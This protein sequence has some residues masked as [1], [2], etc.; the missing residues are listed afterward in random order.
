MAALDA[1][2]AGVTA[3]TVHAAYA[4]VIQGAGYD[5]PFRCGRATG[6]SSLEHPKLVTGDTTIL[7]PGIVFAVD[8][9]LTTD[10]FR[11]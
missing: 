2:K 3:E 5:Y 4:K 7:Q 9:S 10:S 1:L 6:F 8:G 11:A